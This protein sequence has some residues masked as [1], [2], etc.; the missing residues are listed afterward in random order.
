MQNQSHTL[1]TGEAISRV[2]HR[3]PILHGSHGSKAR[4]FAASACYISHLAWITHGSRMDHAWIT[5]RIRPPTG[6]DRP[7]NRKGW[8]PPHSRRVVYRWFDLTATAWRRRS[9]CAR[10]FGVAGCG[11]SDQT[12][13]AGQAGSG[14]VGGGEANALTSWS[15]RKW[16]ATYPASGPHLAIAS[17]RA[18]GAR[19]GRARAS[20]T[21]R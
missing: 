20:A 5:P 15:G 10:R 18:S 21:S 19:C 7:R 13:G 8:G 1:Y 2:M 11:Q 12:D 9:G 4:S 17:A 3:L 14:R 6:R 16:A